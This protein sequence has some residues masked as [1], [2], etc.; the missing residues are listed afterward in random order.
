MYVD[1]V[2]PHLD[3]HKHSRIFSFPIKFS[4]LTNISYYTYKYRPS[5]IVRAQHMCRV[6]LF[7][8]SASL[9]FFN[10]LYW[11]SMFMN[12]S[13]HSSSFTLIICLLF[14]A[15]WPCIDTSVPMPHW[16]YQS[17]TTSCVVTAGMYCSW[18]QTN[19]PLLAQELNTC[20]S[21]TDITLQWLITHSK[22]GKWS[23]DM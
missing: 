19:C 18:A 3:L 20:P 2:H 9:T 10:T 4:T 6:K 14:S 12:I 21:L 7:S 1:L 22:S 15:V 8:I 11:M 16:L 17:I 5:V 13:L 23:T